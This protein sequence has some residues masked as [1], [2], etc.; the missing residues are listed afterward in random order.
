MQAQILAYTSAHSY[1]YGEI[2]SLS[3]LNAASSSTTEAA[4][5]KGSFKWELDIGIDRCR[6]GY[7][8]I[9]GLD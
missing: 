4:C 7:G 9:Y 3:T 5:K 1:V 2:P 8:S 6:C